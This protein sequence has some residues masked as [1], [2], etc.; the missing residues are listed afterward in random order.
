MKTL[1][2]FLAFAFVL[3][4]S[5]LAGSSDTNLPGIGAFAYTGAPIVSSVPQAV[6]V[7]GR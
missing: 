3:A 1:S 2:V 7:A 4:G 6:V 5:S